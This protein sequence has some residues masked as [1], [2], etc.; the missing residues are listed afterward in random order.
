MTKHIGLLTVRV[1]AVFLLS[2]A[3][4]FADAQ[5]ATGSFEVHGRLSRD[6]HDRFQISV[7]GAHTILAIPTDM[8]DSQLPEELAKLFTARNVSVD[9]DFT[10]MP[11]NDYK[12]VAKYPPG[13]KQFVKIESAKNTVVYRGL[14]RDDNAKALGNP[15]PADRP[16]EKVFGFRVLPHYVIPPLGKYL[17]IHYHDG[18]YGA[19]KFT[20]AS[21]SPDGWCSAEYEWYYGIDET[22]HF[23]GPNMRHGTGAVSD[24]PIPPMARPLIRL[25][26]RYIKFESIQLLWRTPLGVDFYKDYRDE[27]RYAPHATLAPTDS[28]DISAISVHDQAIRWFGVDALTAWWNRFGW[29][30][31]QQNE[32]E[33]RNRK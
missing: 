11:L 7:S 20:R 26:N 30:L 32:Q 18:Q 12:P 1:V 10:V 22:G 4:V 24:K 21:G 16:E 29:I 19:I 2:I 17:L 33:R 8:A 25:G 13:V 6:I 28:S 15:P 23:S 5:N 31:R 3:A 9:G 14:L 27:E